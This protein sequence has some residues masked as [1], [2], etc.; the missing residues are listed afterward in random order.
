MAL[1]EEKPSVELSTLLIVIQ[2]LQTE[3]DEHKA[4]LSK[5]VGTSED[6]LWLEDLEKAAS[7]LQRAY[8]THIEKNKIVNFPA[9]EQL[10]KAKKI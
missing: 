2:I 3:I 10:L 1:K 6:Y 9:Y 5:E 7:D 8:T 4:T